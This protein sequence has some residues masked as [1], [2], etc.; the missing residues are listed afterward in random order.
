MKSK[1]KNKIIVLALALLAA[2]PF[3]VFAQDSA[4]ND[5]VMNLGYF[6]KN[7]KV[8]Y[9]MVNTKTKIDKKFQPVEGMVVNLYLDNDS[10]SNLIGK[11]T[12]NEKGLAKAII[13]PNLKTAWDGSSAHT[14][15]GVSASTKQFDETTAEAAIT[16]TKITID[17]LAGAEARTVTASV[18]ALAGG[19]WVPAADVEMKIGIVRSGGS[20]LSAGD[21]PTYTTDST[22]TITAEFKRDMLP[23]DKSGNIVLIAKVE[24]NDQYGNLLSEKTVPWG[25][26]LKPG[27]N[28]F[29]QRTLWTTR[30]RTPLW[31][32]FMAYSII[33]GVW[34]TII[35]L[36]L[37][38]VKIKKLGVA[39]T[40]KV[41]S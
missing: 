25:V 15:L 41:L 3:R 24:D 38:I 37:Q 29:D 35:Y 9:L 1:N 17:T 39:G 31:L 5:L 6:M 14:F 26:A 33:I 12:T 2:A 23:G 20:I 40:N 21:D 34:G 8:V 13:P 30:Y 10:A 16:K 36:V 22:G 19:E 28:F 11:I 7:N 18:F 32:L 4:K 27:K